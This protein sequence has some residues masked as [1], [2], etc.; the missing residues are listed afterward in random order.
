MKFSLKAL[1]AAVIVSVGG[2]A[3][4]QQSL[5]DRAAVNAAGKI[6]NDL[7][8][9]PQTAG[10]K[11]IAFLGLIGDSG[12]YAGILRSAM[13][14]NSG[15]FAFYT[16]NEE[17]WNRLIQEIEF[18]ERRENNMRKES[19][20][21]FG[22]VEGV[23]A[24]LFGKVLEAGISHD[25]NAIFRVA[26]NLVEVETG[27]F[28]WGGMISGLGR[29]IVEVEPVPDDVLQAAIDAGKKLNDDLML[30]KASL[31][32]CNI[33]IMPFLGNDGTALFDAVST[34]IVR[35]FG[36][37]IHFY[38]SPDKLAAA[39]LDDIKSDIKGNMPTYSSKQLNDI[40]SKLQK[41]YNINPKAIGAGKYGNN[42]VNAYLQGVIV[43]IHIDQASKARIVSINVQLRDFSNNRL[44]WSANA[45]GEYSQP[46]SND[47]KLEGFWDN[48]KKT[49][50]VI[51]GAVFLV[52]VLIVGSVIVIRLVVR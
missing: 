38:A 36:S 45:K 20:R 26:L 9:S 49:L 50:T 24:L 29:R 27:R 35:D 8:S 5:I 52:I 6:I 14:G 13:S 11:N 41:A 43:S 28:I 17:L 19:I 21:K 1:L 37:K 34:Q 44:L 33:F 25:G 48:N 30:K 31:P 16:R 39:Q 22:K 51:V 47:S 46:Q 4:G 40:M 32:E 42:R 2:F 7:T 15:R 10:I 12:H 18:G 3:F 23:Q